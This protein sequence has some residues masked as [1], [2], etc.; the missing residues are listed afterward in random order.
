MTRMMQASGTNRQ[1]EVANVYKTLVTVPAPVAAQ[2]AFDAAG[3]NTD[4]APPTAASAAL[5]AL[6]DGARA[7]AI[8][9]GVAGLPESSASHLAA[10]LALTQQPAPAAAEGWYEFSCIVECD[11]AAR[12]FARELEMLCQN[13]PQ[14]LRLVVVCWCSDIGVGPVIAV[15]VCYGARAVAV[16]IA[17]GAESRMRSKFVEAAHGAAVGTMRQDG[18]FTAAFVPYRQPHVR[19]SEGL[20]FVGEPFEPLTPQPAAAP[21]LFTQLELHAEVTSS[22]RPRSDNHASVVVDQL[23][24]LVG[25]ATPEA[26]AGHIEGISRGPG[27][28]GLPHPVTGGFDSSAAVVAEAQAAQPRQLLGEDEGCMVTTTEMQFGGHV[29][30]LDDFGIYGA[31]RN[32]AS[33]PG[34]DRECER[35]RSADGGGADE[36]ARGGKQGAGRSSCE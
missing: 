13:S 8:A 25:R 17:Q 24:P 5:A 19:C 29:Q 14:A 2:P 6:V 7:P 30:I 4:A 15:F 22:K 34:G 1:P 3:M 36:L 27:T 20:P 9:V 11:D 23:A 21:R 28:M 12:Y 35:S 16:E 10:P 18:V 33:D 32:C 26:M 31:G